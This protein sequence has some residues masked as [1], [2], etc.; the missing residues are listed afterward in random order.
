P[1]TL[2]GTEMVEE[3]GVRHDLEPQSARN[4]S[5]LTTTNWD[6]DAQVR[7]THRTSTDDAV[8]RDGQIWALVDAIPVLVWK[9]TADGFVEFFNRG[10]HEYTGLALEHARGWNWMVVVHPDDQ[11][12]L[13]Q[14]WRALL[15]AGQP[16]E[17][18]A[19]M[20]AADGQ[21]RWFLFRC[22]PLRG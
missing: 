4:G 15:Q 5:G 9:A 19:R 17:A 16:G 13:I 12:D 20:R 1:I 6:E 11:K 21:Y 7:G 3:T 22:V 10:W 2:R 18:E 8:A 14:T